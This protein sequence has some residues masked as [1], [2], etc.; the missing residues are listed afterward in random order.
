MSGGQQQRVALARAL[1]PKPQV[2]LLDEPLSALDAKIRVSL[3]EEIRAIQQKLG[4]TTV[5][6]THD[7][8]EALS[9]SD[10]IVVMHGGKADQIGCALRDLQSPRLVANFVGA[11]LSSANA[12]RLALRPEAGSTAPD[13]KGDTALTGEVISSNF[14]GSVIRTRMKV[15]PAII[16]FDMFNSPGLVPPAVGETSTLRF[17]AGDLLIIRD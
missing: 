1:A 13:A 9:I 15:G 11:D 7:Q 3:R 2:L 12:Q 5:F 6:V 4:I 10:R 17:T 14:L 16:S 8:E